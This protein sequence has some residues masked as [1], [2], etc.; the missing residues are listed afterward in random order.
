[1]AWTA[2]ARLTRP[3]RILDLPGLVARIERFQRRRPDTD[4]VR[5]YNHQMVDA[6]DSL[7]PRG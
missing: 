7:R 5:A 4:P 3:P 1:M 6:L 2:H